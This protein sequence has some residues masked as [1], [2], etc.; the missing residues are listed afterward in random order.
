M[1]V[2]TPLFNGWRRPCLRLI[3]YLLFLNADLRLMCV[4]YRNYG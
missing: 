1:P 2:S 3:D 4:C